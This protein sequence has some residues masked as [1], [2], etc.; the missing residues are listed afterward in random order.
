MINEMMAENIEAVAGLIARSRR[1][2]VF[3]G[4]GISTE[5]GIPDFR[6]P[7]GIWT[8]YEPDDFTIQRYRTSQA[9]RKKV[10]RLLIDPD[11][12]F[13][14]AEPN[15]GHLAIAELQT[16]EKL[17]AV[18]T[19][20]IDG[21]HQKAG[22]SG[23]LVFELH[24]DMSHAI[25]LNCSINYTSDQVIQW[26]EGGIEDPPCMECGGMLKPAGIF[27]GEQL[28]PDVL[29][30]AERRC[31]T[32]DLCIVVGSS[33]QVIPAAYLPQYAIQSNAKL[34]IVNIGSTPLDRMAHVR[35][36]D[37][38]SKALPRIM[39]RAGKMLAGD[40]SL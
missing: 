28:P 1:I 36:D 17:Y 6:S 25:C 40:G 31:R 15:P 3:T 29:M 8:K 32:C 39:E 33:L 4:A 20:N 9:V 10:W 24:G 2:V 14:L 21:L 30:E 7:G 34:V 38:S 27:F 26:L 23:D 16:M 22:V 19:Q 35:I 37:K 11:L 13:G 18:V 12:K 5:S